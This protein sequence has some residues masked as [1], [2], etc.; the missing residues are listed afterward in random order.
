MSYLE[1]LHI[2]KSLDNKHS[3]KFVCFKSL[4]N[5]KFCVQNADFFYLPITAEQLSQSERQ[6]IELFIEISPLKRCKW[7]SSLAEAISF[8][9]KEFE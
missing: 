9:E 5:E 3:I 6:E 8:H 2:W 7:F 1:K 4:S